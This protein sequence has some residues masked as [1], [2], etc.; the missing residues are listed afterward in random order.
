[1]LR[2]LVGSEMCIRD[3]NNIDPFA[4]YYVPNWKK[5]VE[6]IGMSTSL[7]ITMLAEIHKVTDS[8]SAARAQVLAIMWKQG[9]T[10]NMY[11]PTSTRYKGLLEQYRA[12][13]ITDLVTDSGE[14]F[15]VPPDLWNDFARRLDP[16]LDKA[17]KKQ[18]DAAPSLD[19][20][21]GSFSGYMP[22]LGGSLQGRG[23]SNNAGGAK[24]NKPALGKGGK[25]RINT[26]ATT[27][28]ATSGASMGS[29]S[30]AG[31][32]GTKVIE[33]LRPVVTALQS[34]N[35]YTVTF[36]FPI[37]FTTIWSTLLTVFSFDLLS[38]LTLNVPDIVLPA[39]QLSGGILLVVLVAYF[40]YTDHATWAL[41][42]AKYVQRRDQVD[43]DKVFVQNVRRYNPIALATTMKAI[44]L[45]AN[46]TGPINKYA[47]LPVIQPAAAN[48][49]LA[50]STKA[51]T[52]YVRQSKGIRR[53]AKELL[54][55]H[56]VAVRSRAAAQ[57]GDIFGASFGGSQSNASFL[58]EGT[59]SQDGTATEFNIAQEEERHAIRARTQR[60]MY[61]LLRYV[62]PVK[63]SLS[64]DQYCD[65]HRRS[66]LLELG[67]SD[68]TPAIGDGSGVTW[69]ISK[70][71]SNSSWVAVSVAKKGDDV[72]KL[73]DAMVTVPDQQQLQAAVDEEP[74][75]G[76]KRRA[77]VAM[78]EVSVTSL[79]HLDEEAAIV[80]AVSLNLQREIDRPP[81]YIA[82]DH[83]CLL[84]TSDAAD[85]EDS[86]DLGGRRIIKKKKKRKE[87][88]G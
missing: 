63:I 34:M 87:E 2:S 32:A 77:S 76:L 9:V 60:W 48:S 52:Y 43:A 50:A 24:I 7:F 53:T 25:V 70:E 51:T 15:M 44:K 6:V 67:A 84:Y 22:K 19:Q 16:A 86:V 40:T 56:E 65:E 33:A 72:D 73:K 12:L 39:I 29:S 82:M 83:D 3:R 59:K 68:L 26:N 54:R 38:Y 85:E 35:I 80:K 46:A 78:S 74:S 36:P 23:G 10:N 75:P 5:T 41:I 81:G 8:L 21:N 31:S 18:Q 71:Q 62:L 20:S 27:T 45:E 37:S 14:S 64:I 69:C 55:M 58:W 57:V 4:L 1:M 11:E 28:S 17:I 13:L 49:S 42:V 61:P 47:P 88:R 66:R 30:S 79:N